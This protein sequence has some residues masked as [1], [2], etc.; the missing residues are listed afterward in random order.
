MSR[1]IIIDRLVSLWNPANAL[2]L[3]PRHIDS[4]E[5]VKPLAT[6]KEF[7]RRGLR[8]HQRRVRYFLDSL[9]AGETLEPIVIDNYADRG[10]IYAYPVVDDGNHRLIAHILAGHDTI[11]AEYSG[12]L[13]VLR[14]LQGYRKRPPSD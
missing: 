6:F 4:I 9:Q 7:H 1:R 2:D 13:D 8:Y 11:Q 14:F 3:K 10:R 12:R 5:D